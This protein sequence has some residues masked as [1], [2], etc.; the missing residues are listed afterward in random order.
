MPTKVGNQYVWGIDEKGQ[1]H[2][3]WANVPNVVYITERSKPE[4]L[5]LLDL[6]ENLGAVTVNEGDIK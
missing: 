4:P 2:D 1:P 3:E 5:N 6:P